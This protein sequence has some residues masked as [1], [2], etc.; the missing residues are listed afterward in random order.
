MFRDKSSAKRQKIWHFVSYLADKRRVCVSARL[1]A[2]AGD[3]GQ[4]GNGLA[5]AAGG[6]IGGIAK[7]AK[8]L[9]GP[10]SRAF[11]HLQNCVCKF[12]DR[13]ERRLRRFAMRRMSGPRNNR[14]INRTIALFPRDLDLA[15]SPILVV[16]ALQ[17]RD[18]HADVGEIFRNI[19]VAK[20]RI[21]PGAVPAVEGVVDIAV[22][23]LQLRPAGRWSRRPS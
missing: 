14:H 2:L 10:S 8:A 6:V 16:G 5:P 4:C 20:F 19:P 1:G 9:S 23:A 21:E 15:N 3:I 11:V 17:D 18:R 13:I 12:R 22:P 7:P